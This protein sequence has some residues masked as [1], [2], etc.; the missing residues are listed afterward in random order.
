MDLIGLSGEAKGAVEWLKSIEETEEEIDLPI[1]HSRK[2]KELISG[3]P[4]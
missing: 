3:L 2:L 4:Q 1:I